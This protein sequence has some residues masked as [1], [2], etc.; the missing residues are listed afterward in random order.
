MQTSHFHVFGIGQCSLD[1]IGAVDQYPLPDTKCEFDNLNIVGGGPVAT[2]LVALSRWGLNCAFAGI[3]GDDDFSN[4]IRYSLDIEG[5]DL[6][7]LLVRIGTLSQ[8][9]FI[10]AERKSG[11]RTI[12]WQRPTGTALLPE[13]IDMHILKRCRV[14]HT[15]GL[16]PDASLAACIEAKRSGIPVVVDAGT[17]REGMSE[18]ARFSDYFIASERC[19]IALTGSDEPLDA[20]KRILEFGPRLAAVTIGSRGY[21]AAHKGKLIRKPA[22]PVEAIDTTGCGD[23]FHAGFIYGLLQQWT[24]EKGLDLGAWAASRVSLEFGGRAGIPSL[25]EIRNRFLDRNKNHPTV[26]GDQ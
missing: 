4:M 16:F 24:I 20:C 9:A 23:I 17:W 22:Y 5:I 10:T 13:E 18:I 7:G 14:L 21:V 26:N 1:Y 11:A 15:D 25:M 12:F 2:A 6:S 3:T 19:G 8:F